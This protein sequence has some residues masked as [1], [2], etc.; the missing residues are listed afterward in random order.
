[1]LIVGIVGSSLMPG[2]RDAAASAT[3]GSAPVAPPPTTTAVGTGSTPATT[4]PTAATVTTVAPIP[5]AIRCVSPLLLDKRETRWLASNVIMVGINIRDGARARRLVQT[6]NIA[7]ILV[8]GTPR[9]K[10]AALLLSIRNARADT[11]TMV[12]V[13]EEG[14]RV[15]HLRVAIG[16]IPSAKVMAATKTV[17]EVRA[18]ARRHGTA[19]RKMGFTVDFG[20][21]LDLQF[22]PEKVNGIGD[23]AFSSDP[24]VVTAYAGAFAQGLLDAGIYPVVKHFPGGGRANGDPHYKGTESPGIDELRKLDLLPFA[25]LIRTMPIGVMS[26]HQRVPGLGSVPASLSPLA[27]TGVLRKELGFNG[28]AVTDSLSMWSIAFN[29]DR[30]QAATLAL[31]AGNDLLLFDDEPDVEA[32]IRGLTESVAKDPTLRPRL[33]NAT[34]N[35]LRAKGIPLCAGAPSLLPSTTTSTT[36]DK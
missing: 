24:A 20:P 11:S 33:V 17:E 1:M 8:R 34:T 6:Q 36:V 25:D 16:P 31:K 14:G 2:H 5:E 26:G 21:V 12:A 19:M 13:D 35:V 32:I 27:I 7:G 23:R 3:S 9:A 10:D 18:I 29:F 22:G 4:A 28:L 15:Q 30:V